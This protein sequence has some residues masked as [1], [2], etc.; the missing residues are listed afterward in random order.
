MYDNSKMRVS[1]HVY[2]LHIF[3]TICIDCH[4]IGMTNNS[5][6]LFAYKNCELKKKNKFKNRKYNIAPI[7]HFFLTLFI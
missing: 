7:S 4:V 2:A 5:V 6:M 1:C 3:N